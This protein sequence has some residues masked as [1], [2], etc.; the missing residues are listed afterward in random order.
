V[1]LSI[2]T[3]SE[4][5]SIALTEGERTVDEILLRSP[6]GFGHILYGHVEQLL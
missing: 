4:F 3:T 2:D 5:A 1:I 6:D